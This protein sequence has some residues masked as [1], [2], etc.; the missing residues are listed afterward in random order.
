MPSIPLPFV[1][2]IVLAILLIRLAREEKPGGGLAIIAFVAVCALLATL[3]GLR[4]SYR[5]PPAAYLQPVLASV[6]PALAWLS[7]ADLIRQGGRH[8]LHALPPI[9]VTVM[10]AVW[11]EGLDLALLAIYV[12]YGA[13]LLWRGRLGSDGLVRA[14]LGEVAQTHGAM[15]LAG[16]SLVLA[17]LIDAAIAL[18]LVATGGGY[19]ATIVT[20]ANLVTLL[21]TAYCVAVAGNSHVPAQDRSEPE[22]GG[23]LSAVNDGDQPN[24]AGDRDVIEIIDRLMRQMQLFRDPNL[25]LDRIARRA[26]IPARQISGAVNRIHGRNV[27]QFVNEYRVTDAAH[28]LAETDHPVT[29]IMLDAG[30]QTKSNFNREFLRVMGMSPSAYRRSRASTSAGITSTEAISPGNS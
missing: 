8:G 13:M 27:S 5:W 3:T 23:A 1:I 19:V 25:S 17:G 26:R 11:R 21:L 16:I 9:A 29:T 7:F 12:C 18:D 2:S 20:V 14:R 15:I 30:F 28:K 24:E 6:L 10:T 22:A 4:W